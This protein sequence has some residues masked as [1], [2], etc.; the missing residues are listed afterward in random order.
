VFERVLDL[1]KDIYGNYVISH[2]LDHGSR[3]D[4][5]FV[6]EKIKGRVVNL[7]M[8][9]FGSNVIEKC[10]VHADRNQREELIH[11]IHN[12]KLYNEGNIAN[13]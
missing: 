9:K 7:S 3:A 11:E 6:I 12:I 8:H 10:L 4:K 2:V 1:T 13:H 5:D